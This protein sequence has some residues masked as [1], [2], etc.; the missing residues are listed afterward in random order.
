MEGAGP[1]GNIS[2]TQRLA[3]PTRTRRGRGRNLPPRGALEDLNLRRF[4]A[5]ANALPLSTLARALRSLL[6]A[7]CVSDHVSCSYSPSRPG[8]L[9]RVRGRPHV[10]PAL[11]CGQ[12]GHGHA[13]PGC[14]SGSR[15][16]SPRGGV[17]SSAHSTA[18]DG[19]H[20][21]LTAPPPAPA[22]VSDSLRPTLRRERRPASRN[23]EHLSPR[24]LCSGSK[25][26]GPGVSQPGPCHSRPIGVGWNH[27]RGQARAQE[28]RR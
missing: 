27:S 10:P 4:G 26:A 24:L 14:A 23:D 28:G 20:T 13:Q 21:T 16:R 3:S 2:E 5:P 1:Q 18:P 19:P 9:P 12:T 7:P 6:S 11:C 15:A 8:G 17:L 25:P 22:G